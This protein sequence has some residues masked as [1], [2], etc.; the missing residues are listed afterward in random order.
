MHIPSEAYVRQMIDDTSRDCGHPEVKRLHNQAVADRSALLAESAQ[1]EAQSEAARQ[2][3]LIGQQK[4]ADTAAAL[5]VRLPYPLQAAGAVATPAEKVLEVALA[6]VGVVGNFV[7]Y[8][9]VA[10]GV[11][12]VLQTATGYRIDPF[13]GLPHR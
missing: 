9:N 1:R 7:P 3:R 6:A 12:N 13:P 8:V 10:M 5:N 11:L 2:D 4:A